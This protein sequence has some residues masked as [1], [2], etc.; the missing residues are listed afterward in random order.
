MVVAKRQEHDGTYGDGVIAIL[1]G[2]DQ[3]PLGDAADTQ[4]SRVRLVDNRQAENGAKLA[5]I[6]DREGGTLDVFGLELLVAGALTEVGDAT[7]QPEEVQ[8]PGILQ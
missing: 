3:G 5:G 1:V 6:G 8:V 2:Y 4:D 7:L